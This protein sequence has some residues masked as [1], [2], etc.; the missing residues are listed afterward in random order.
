MT[1]KEM[2]ET[3]C[4]IVTV[5]ISIRDDGKLLHRIKIGKFAEADKFPTLGKTRWD[6][7]RVPINYYDKG[8]EYF[9]YVPG[10]IPKQLEAMRVTRWMVLPEYKG[11]RTT[12]HELKEL[13]LD[14]ERD[15]EVVEGEGWKEIQDKKEIKNNQLE[16][17]LCL[18][19]MDK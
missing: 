10:S 17:Q 14:V 2:L 9:G 11:Y 4:N 16:G 6:A 5:D 18:F 7:K 8:K 12:I 19:D 1:V 15:M 13:Y 3:N